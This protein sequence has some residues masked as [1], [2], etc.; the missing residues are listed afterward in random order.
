MIDE[1]DLKILSA[2]DTNARMTYIQL[3]KQLKLNKSKVQYR[4]SNLINE[5]IIKK[6]VTQPSLNKL[7]FFLAKFYLIL[8]G[9]SSEEKNLFL[10]SL[11]KEKRI[12]WVAKTQG[13]WDVMIG[14]FVKN[15]KELLFIKKEILRKYSRNIESLDVSLLGEGYT[16]QRKY[17]FT[18]NPQNSKIIKDYVGEFSTSEKLNDHEKKIL[19]LI[20][21]NARFNYVNLCEKLKLDVK[22]LKKKIKTLE[23]KKIIQGYVTFLDIKK[24]GYQFFKICIYLKNHEDLD[25]II[26]FGLNHPNVVHVIETIGS[27]DLEFEIETKS[28]EDLFKIE[29]EIK[30][31]YPESI[32]KTISTII[33]DEIKLD[34]VPSEL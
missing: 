24:L 1:V 16:S 18:I 27:W 5:G 33:E 15:V 10:D 6:F 20:S 19:Q 4:L 3:S 26:N 2:I 25:K 22:T 13:Q 12:C 32:R 8:S 7:G 29:E 11:C 14:V 23:D 30:N 21:N 9:M 34:F 28:F 17:L 31:K